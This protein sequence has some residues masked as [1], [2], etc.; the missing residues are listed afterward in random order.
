[1]IIRFIVD[2]IQNKPMKV[3]EVNC[4]SWRNNQSLYIING[5][6]HQFFFISKGTTQ[7]CY[8][9][10]EKGI[11]TNNWFFI[12]FYV[13]MIH[14][15]QT[16]MFWS[17]LSFGNW[18]LNDDNKRLV[19]LKSIKSGHLSC[20]SVMKLQVQVIKI[21]IINHFRSSDWYWYQ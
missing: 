7:W 20:M 5:V 3:F 1:M 8:R 10:I 12:L 2:G 11:N 14:S 13:V 17:K 9:R 16:M 18:M 15:I 4:D 21:W 6:I 19:G